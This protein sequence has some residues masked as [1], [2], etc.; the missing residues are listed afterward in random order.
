MYVFTAAQKTL[1]YIIIVIFAANASFKSYGVIC[2]PRMPLTSYSEAT[3]YRYQ[4]NP[5]NVGM[6]LLFAVL[7]KN[8]SFRS[9]STFVYLLRAHILNINT[10]TYT[11]SA[12]GHE[13][14]GCVRAD[15]YNLILI[16]ASYYY[17]PWPWP[18]IY[19][20]RKNILKMNKEVGMLLPKKELIQ[21]E[22]IAKINNYCEDIYIYTSLQQ[23]PLT[24]PIH[25]KHTHRFHPLATPASC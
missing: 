3:K 6:T 19:K 20:D 16:F 25:G 15:A 13:L 10:C 12:H 22:Y 5:R 1:L 11:T 17:A 18:C 24:T 2:L 8:D 4:R 7:T 23:H 14:S 21:V 9:Y